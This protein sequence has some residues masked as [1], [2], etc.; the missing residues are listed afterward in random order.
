M[1]CRDWA[2][3]VAAAAEFRLAGISYLK[4][5]S[6]LGGSGNVLKID[7]G[8][9][10]GGGRNFSRP[11]FLYQGNGASDFPR[12][13]RRQTFRKHQAGPRGRQRSHW[14]VLWGLLVCSI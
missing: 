12:L 8:G 7:H 6:F 5:I 10:G 2:E 1:T 9:G 11:Q 13:A 14:A 3:S 4:Q